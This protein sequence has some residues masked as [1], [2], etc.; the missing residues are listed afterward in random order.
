MTIGATLAWVLL[1]TVEERVSGTGLLTRE[2]GLTPID[3]PVDGVVAEVSASV[4]AGVEA[5]SP[6][7][8]LS[9]PD[10]T[11]VPVVSP[12]GGIVAATSATPGSVIRV[13]QRLATIEPIAGPLAATV[14]VDALAAAEIES[15]MEAL[16]WPLGTSPAEEGA[17]I[18]VVSHV[19]TFPATIAQLES[20]LQAAPLVAS[21][22][23]SAVV[24]V[25]IALGPEGSFDWTLADPAMSDIQPGRVVE[26][27]VT[28]SSQRPIDAI[29]GS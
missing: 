15:G 5:G 13:G 4:G 6:V 11:T 10:G 21:L 20:A 23:T 25:T 29:V 16:V 26:A 28:V 8:V 22:S 7:A 12:V 24:E 27:R 19:S 18:G 17:A 1:G 14:F 2:P 3:A 9:A